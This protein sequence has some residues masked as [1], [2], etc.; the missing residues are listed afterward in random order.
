MQQFGEHSR[1]FTGNFI[2]EE[3]NKQKTKKKI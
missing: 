2:K 1:K 3:K